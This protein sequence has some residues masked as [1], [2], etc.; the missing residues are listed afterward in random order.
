MARQFGFNL[1]LSLNNYLNEHL[2][3]SGRDNWE[4][5]KVD[6]ISDFH[7]DVAMDLQAIKS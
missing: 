4:Q 5:A 7:A 6:E 2:G 1:I 3:L